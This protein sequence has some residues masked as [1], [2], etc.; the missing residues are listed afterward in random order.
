MRKDHRPYVVKKAVLRFQKFYSAH[1]L[2]P[3]FA[4]LGK[5]A[6]IIKPWYVEV[7][8]SPVSVG[9]H[10]T[11]VATSD[12]RVR[13]SVW[14]DEQVSGQ[15]Q[16]GDYVIICPGVRVSS[17][18]KIHIG[19]N[20]MLASGV[21]LT[22]SDW[23]DIYNRIAI[24][25]TDPIHI[26]DNVWIGDGAIVCKGVSIGEN[27][28]IGAGSVVVNSIPSDCIAAGNPARVVKHLDPQKSFTTRQQW[29]LKSADL[30]AEIDQLDRE[31]MRG[32][33]LWHWL[34]YLFFPRKGD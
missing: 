6:T 4:A 30:Y 8:G 24:G 28:I 29:F 31:I 1:F 11:I 19:D 13:L 27:T 18:S 20:C 10:V 16:I 21:Y 5:F 26:T 12:H 25:K 15:I 33:T 22:D 34:R 3:H 23:H 32:N 9:D 14:S 2:Q 7:F 17:A